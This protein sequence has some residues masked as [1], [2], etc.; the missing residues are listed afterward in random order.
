MDLLAGLGTFYGLLSQE[1][2]FTFRVP[3]PKTAWTVSISCPHQSDPQETPKFEVY[4]PGSILL[5]PVQ[6]LPL[7]ADL[8]SHYNPQ[9]SMFLQSYG[10]NALHPYAIRVKNVYGLDKDTGWVKTFEKYI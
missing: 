10:A 4:L 3:Y 8:V 7:S 1:K 6:W 5:T 9:I 2:N